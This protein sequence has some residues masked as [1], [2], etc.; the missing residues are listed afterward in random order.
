MTACVQGPFLGKSSVCE[1]IL[2]SLPQWFGVE[3]STAQYVRDIGDH[4][5]FLASVEGQVVGFL[6][7]RHHSEYAAE[8]HVMGVRPEAHRQGIGRALIIAAQDFL[9]ERGVVFLQVK[10]LGPSNPDANY[11]RTRAF[12]AAMGFR[13]LEEFE[14]LWDCP[15]LLMVK[16]IRPRVQ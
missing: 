11:A 5:T 12:Y 6:A 7:L 15:C 3:E 9:R 8:I 2:R 1:P 4:P 10:T 13:Q 14:H 16:S